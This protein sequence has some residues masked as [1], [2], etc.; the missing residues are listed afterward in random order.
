M[1][2]SNRISVLLNLDLSAWT[3][4]CMISRQTDDAYSFM[5]NSYFPR[6]PLSLK[7]QQ[8]IEFL[9]SKGCR[10]AGSDSMCI[11]S[12]GSGSAPRKNGDRKHSHHTKARSFHIKTLFSIEIAIEV[13]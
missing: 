4:I 5:I 7:I 10:N 11:L 8:I 13:S 2:P 6:T 12:A 9:H 1:H 3:E